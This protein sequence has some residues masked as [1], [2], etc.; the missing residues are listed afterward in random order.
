MVLEHANP[1]MDTHAHARMHAHE[2]TPQNKYTCQNSLEYAQEVTSCKEG[3]EVVPFNW[4]EANSILA[5]VRDALSGL[6]RAE[7]AAQ[8]ATT[9]A[10]EARVPTLFESEGERDAPCLV[11]VV[12]RVMCGLLHRARYW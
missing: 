5:R 10:E 8:E 1:H 6:A 7:S 9:F 4:Q 11:R 12:C 2:P 3:Q